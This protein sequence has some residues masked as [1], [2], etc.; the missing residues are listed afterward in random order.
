MSA[1]TLTLREK[2]AAEMKRIAIANGMPLDDAEA[3]HIMPVIDALLP[4]IRE[5]AAGVFKREWLR[6]DDKDED[7]IRAALLCME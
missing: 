7:A 2:L 6:F 5:H 3:E 4:I 1:E